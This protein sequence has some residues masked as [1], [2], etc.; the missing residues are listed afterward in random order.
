MQSPWKLQGKPQR[1]CY[2]AYL[3]S[4]IYWPLFSLPQFIVLQANLTNIQW[5][6]KMN[7]AN[8]WE[9]N[10]LCR[11][12]KAYHIAVLNRILSLSHLLKN[13]KFRSG[14]KLLSH[15]TRNHSVIQFCSI[16]YFRVIST[17]KH[18]KK[19]IYEFQNVCVSVNIAICCV[20]T[21][22]WITWNSRIRVHVVWSTR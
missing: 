19:I 10:G 5:Q 9:N 2:V 3:Y 12:Y 6:K 15:K 22:L 18:L 21:W 8:W 13:W 20:I 7:T 4:I 16:S 1:P 14:C 11:Y 17:Y